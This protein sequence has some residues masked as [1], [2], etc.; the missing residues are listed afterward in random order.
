MLE[1]QMIKF[2]L[3]KWNY[4]NFRIV[5]WDQEEF[6]VGNQPAKF[7]LIFKEKIPFLKLFSD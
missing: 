7:S 4:G 2:I 5:F 6:H 3:S 1:K